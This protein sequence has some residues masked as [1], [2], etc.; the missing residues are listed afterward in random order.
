MHAPALFE[1]NRCPVLRVDEACTPSD[2]TAARI[3]QARRELPLPSSQVMITE[4][5]TGR[6]RRE[7]ELARKP[8]KVL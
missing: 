1:R 4:A 5:R 3:E 2:R 8:P 7:L 6:L